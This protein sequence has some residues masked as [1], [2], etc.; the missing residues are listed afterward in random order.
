MF[1]KI[2]FIMLFVLASSSFCYKAA[3]DG[4]FISL[5]KHGSPKQVLEA[6]KK[7]ANVNAGD[8]ITPLIALAGY[9]R[10][11]I[12]SILIEAGADIN[13]RDAEGMTPLMYFALNDME[14]ESTSL[15]IESG[16]DVNAKDY[17][18]KSV[19]M[20]TLGSM[21]SHGNPSLIPVLVKNGADIN[22]RDPMGNTVLQYAAHIVGN[23]GLI[24]ELLE[25]G[26]DPR[27]K[28]DSGAT[29]LM[30]A[31]SRSDAETVRFFLDLGLPVDEKDDQGFTAFMHAAMSNGNPKVFDVLIKAGAE[32]DRRDGGGATP[33]IN[34]VTSP[35]GSPEVLRSLVRGGAKVNAVD[36]EGR[37]ALIRASQ[38]A[39]DHEMITTLIAL[40]A[41]MT[42]KDREG[43]TALDYAIAS[44]QN[45][46]ILKILGKKPTPTYELINYRKAV[47]EDYPKGTRVIVRGEVSQVIGKNLLINTRRE[48]YIGYIEDPV[49]VK[50]GERVRAL[51]KDLFVVQGTYE[52]L[53]DIKDMFGNTV[54]I[55]SIKAHKYEARKPNL[56]DNIENQMIDDIMSVF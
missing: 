25:N 37:T 28:N 15:I 30:A 43:K 6:I 8:E 46:G 50:V 19:L 42:I 4:D 39:Y 53:V 31:A 22:Y 55:P 32:V 21:A 47:F 3:A 49:Y 2:C 54:S 20:Y 40:G 36:N 38:H 27:I 5:C 7:G 34:S 17:N 26:A 33:L 10:P 23:F 13:Y 29:I 35:C 16:A 9:N 11:E 12:I 14:L 45:E 56:G 51:K 18:G 41:D 52:G 1:K 44:G 48:P 24:K